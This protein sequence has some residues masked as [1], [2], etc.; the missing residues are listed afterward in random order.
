MAQNMA[1]NPVT[2]TA[3]KRD[4]RSGLLMIDQGKMTKVLGGV[5]ADQQRQIDGLA[6]LVARRGKVASR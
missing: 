1:A 6:A 5:V 2:A 4:P 3:V